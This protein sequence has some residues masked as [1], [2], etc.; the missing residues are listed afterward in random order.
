M[1]DLALLT[2]PV[3]YLTWQVRA[4][5]EAEHDVQLYLEATPQ[6]AVDDLSQPVVSET[7]SGE[8]I[9]F[10]RTGTVEQNILGK[11]GDNVRI[12]WGYFYLAIPSGKGKI[13]LADYYDSK[14][15]FTASGTLPEGAQSI[16]T[17]NM[18]KEPVALA[19]ANDL[20]KVGADAVCDYVLL[21]YDD[22]YSIQYFGENL[23]PYW[24]RTG[25]NDIRRELK[26]AAD[27]YNATLDRCETFD[28]EMM[29]ATEE[30]GGR[31]YA[32]LCAL[33][34]RQA[35]AAHK[36]VESPQ[37]E[38]L[39]L[40]KENFSNGSIGTVDIS[41]PSAPLFLLYNP[42]LQKAMM[43]SI[44]EY[45]RSDRWGFP[46]AAHDLGIYPHANG[47]RYSITR[48]NA[49]GGFEGNM[50]L[51]E[52]GNMVTLCAMLSMLDGNTSF[53]DQYWDTIKLWTDYLVENGQDPENQLCTD[54]F[55]GH[56]AHNANLSMKAIMGIAGFSEMARMKGDI[57]T[58]DKY[59]A[60]AKEMAEK[61]ESMANDGDHYRLA[62]DRK[63]TWGQKYNMVWDKLW[64]LNLIPNNAMKREVAYYLRKQNAYGLPLDSRSDISKTDWIMWS[65]AMAD[66]DELFLR[67][68]GPLYK[69]INE[70]SS[71]VPISDYYNTKTGNM[72]GF[73]AR[74]VV[75]GHWM[76]VLMD[77][78]DK[79]KVPSTGISS[80]VT[81]N[82]S[83]HLSYYNL[84]GVK[85]SAPVKGVNIV[86]DDK[87]D[88]RKIV[89]E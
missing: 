18:L 83:G 59:M 82:V 16:R 60:K 34:Y 31:S 51:E 89:M 43:R 54:D 36:L 67:F 32:E 64:G 63:G 22:L 6:F 77:N 37:G 66:T 27:P 86:K 85:M 1:D 17:E 72:V 44:F 41:Y 26:A 70:T 57:E 53:A 25:E 8:G 23:R 56:W 84:N 40:S 73:K 12:D 9:D 87:G 76:K 45:C 78:F 79:T 50:P 35:I 7:G 80:A 42:E 62:Y 69:Y 47:Q 33:A 5:D 75:G 81:D 4:V 46:F 20:G 58:A 24:N 29:Q 11:K 71:R 15:A 68:V 61:W 38:L 88:A 74:S 3:N 48:P 28:R 10:V 55:A 52:S 19:Y 65:A 39:W 13:A 21:G 14:E 49:D 2:R 30:A